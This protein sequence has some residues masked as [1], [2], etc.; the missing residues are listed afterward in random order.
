MDLVEPVNVSPTGWR[1]VVKNA[2]VGA[3]WA[4]VGTSELPPGRR[5]G[6]CIEFYQPVEEWQ[7]RPNGVGR[8]NLGNTPT[9]GFESRN[10]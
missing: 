8:N 1:T 4:L 3:G 2:Q 7:T 10:G 5:S 6:F 9:S